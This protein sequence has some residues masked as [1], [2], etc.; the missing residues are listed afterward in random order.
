MNKRINDSI[1]HLFFHSSI[2]SPLEEVLV[3]LA[4]CQTL[5]STSYLS[6][7]RKKKEP[8]VKETPTD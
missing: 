8:V 7:F 3:I 6:T 5:G 4:Q 2:H 1:I